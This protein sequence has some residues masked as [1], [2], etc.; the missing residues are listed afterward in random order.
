MCC[1]PNGSG[2]GPSVS[3][4]PI[5]ASLEA[6]IDTVGYIAPGASRATNPVTQA[7]GGGFVAGTRLVFV[8][9]APLEF[10]AD[11]ESYQVLLE[12]QSSIDAGGSWQTAGSV[13]YVG[14]QPAGLGAPRIPLPILGQLDFTTAPTGDNVQLRILVTNDASSTSGVLLVGGAPGTPGIPRINFTL[15]SA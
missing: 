8:A 5:G 10:Q 13:V 4:P 7:M 3:T 11:G 15:A 1:N 12:L 2:G 9:M 14:L 6:E